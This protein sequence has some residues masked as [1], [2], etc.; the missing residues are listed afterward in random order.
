MAPAFHEQLLRLRKQRGLTQAE[1]ANSIG[2]REKDI[3]R[4]ETGKNLPQPPAVRRLAEALD[5]PDL[6][7]AALDRADALDAERRARRGRRRGT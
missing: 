4:W 6:V 7:Q 2:G 5:A 3:A 1:L